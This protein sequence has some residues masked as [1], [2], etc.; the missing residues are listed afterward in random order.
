MWWTTMD[1]RETRLLQ[2]ELNV[3]YTAGWR[4]L[5]RFELLLRRN[6]VV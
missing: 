4:A 1:F 5:G 2:V 3:G 6:N